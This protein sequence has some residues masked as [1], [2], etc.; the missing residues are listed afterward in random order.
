VRKRLRK[1]G[2]WLPWVIAVVLILVLIRRVYPAVD[3]DR[4]SHPAPDFE[5][6]DLDGEPFRL[7]DHRGKVIVLNFWATWC[8][9]CRAEIPAFIR[10]QDELR[11]EGVLFVGIS[12][13]DEGLAA[14]A[15]FAAARGINYPILPMGHAV[16]ARFGGVHAL[17]TTILIDRDG[18]IRF[19][20]EGFL[21]PQALRPSIRRLV[22]AAP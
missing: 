19:R 15:P 16:A 22:K 6:L 17:P 21:L 1:V 9:P 12:L 13:D 14:V 7:S 20:H 8:P 10:L 2:R 18:Q 5:L 11:E 4:E 3:L